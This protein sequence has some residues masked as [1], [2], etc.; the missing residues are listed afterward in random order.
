MSWLR[1]DSIH[2]QNDTNFTRYLALTKRTEIFRIANMLKLTTD[3]IV[4]G[5]I[6]F[7]IA[8]QK[9][10]LVR[11]SCNF[12]ENKIMYTSSEASPTVIKHLLEENSRKKTLASYEVFDVP[13]PSMRN[14]RVHEIATEIFTPNNNPKPI[15][16]KNPTTINDIPTSVIKT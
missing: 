12:M 14:G 16:P 2:E 15:A 9:W 5:T 7:S 11:P 8:L 4:T 6:M 1:N 10:C 13:R 3:V